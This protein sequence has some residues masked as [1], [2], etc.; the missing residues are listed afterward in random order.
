MSSECDYLVAY[1]KV[2]EDNDGIMLQGVYF[3]GIG[4]TYQEASDIARECVNNTRGG[5]ILP[6]VCEVRGKHQILEALYDVTDRFENITAQMAE[7]DKTIKRS[8]R[9]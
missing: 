1:A 3:G 7:A 5:T 8:A 6:K 2:V 4:K 9:R